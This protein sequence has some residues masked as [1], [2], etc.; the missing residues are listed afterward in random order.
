MSHPTSQAQLQPCRHWHLAWTQGILGALTLTA[1]VWLGGCAHSAKTTTPPVPT[2]TPAA[3]AAAADPASVLQQ[4]SM[5][6]PPASAGV[7]PQDYR[8]GAGDVVEIKVF[9]AEQLNTTARV[10]GDGTIRFPAVG[11]IIVG[12]QSERDLE[13]QIENKLRGS[14][15]QEPHVTVFVKEMKAQESAIFGEIAKPGLYPISGAEPLTALISEAGGLT[16]Q[17]GPN[18]YVLRAQDRTTTASAQ[19]SAD[20]EAKTPSHSERIDLN[21]LLLRGEQRWN[22]LIYPGDSVTIPEVGWIHVTGQGLQK[23]GTF[24]LRNTQNTFTQYI[25]EAGGVR[26]VADLNH[27][28]IMRRNI[29]GPEEI[30]PVNYKS[31]IASPLN[32]VPV[33]TGDTIVV[34]QSMTKAVVYALGQGIAKVFNVVVTFGGNIRFFGNNNSSSSSF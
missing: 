15:L 30:I 25:D 8:I 20:K 34:N 7:K 33:Q 21:A 18:A 10:G 31:I 14:Y 5:L 3:Q 19:A 16:K 1:G 29:H 2:I 11:V 28:V 17:A 26:F 12:G 23:P 32:D 13:G 22:V 4:A 6:A 27:I 24:P 9:E